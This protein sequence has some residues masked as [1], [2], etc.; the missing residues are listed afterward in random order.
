MSQISPPIRIVLVAAIAF[1]GAYMLF[2]RPKDEVVPPAEP[3]PNVQTDAP[4]V[5]K[6][7]KVVEAAQGAVAAA[8]G[9]LE[10]QE[11]VDGVDAGE[12]AAGTQAGTTTAEGAQA[13]AAAGSAV[14]VAGLP[15]PVAKAIR[16]HKTLV[17]LFWNGKS[18]DDKAVHKALAK[19]DR[20][21]G[22]VVVASAPIKQ[23]SKYGRI[24][25][26]VDVEQSPTVVVADSQLRADTLVGYVDTTTIDQAVVDAF[27]NTGGVFTDPYLKKVDAVCRE[28]RSAFNKIPNSYLTAS[29]TEFAGVIQRVSTVYPRFAASFKSVKAPAK[30]R[31]FRAATVA[32][33]KAAAAYYTDLA[34]FLGPHP[35]RARVVAASSKFASRR[36]SINGKYT[37]RMMRARLTRCVS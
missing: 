1:I 21:D 7:G 20:W 31:S 24:A 32:D 16:K 2:L 27:R 37:P 36:T 35:T 33:N 13:T 10:Q 19:V 29:V 30:W 5:S 28:Y 8:N 22:R 34:A 4:A 14:D 17:L 6:P 15:K 3:A 26:G 12:A 9:Q 18:A 25:R 11:S 23:I